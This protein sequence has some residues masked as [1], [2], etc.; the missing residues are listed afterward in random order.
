MKLYIYVVL[1]PKS[2]IRYTRRSWQDSGVNHRLAKKFLT[3]DEFKEMKRTWK[4]FWLFPPPNS[5][6]IALQIEKNL[7][8]YFVD[9]YK[10]TNLRSFRRSQAVRFARFE[11][12]EERRS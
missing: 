6:M 7:N 2:T 5:L 4:Q 10:M 11:G 1:Q 8:T 12:A 3:D 9:I